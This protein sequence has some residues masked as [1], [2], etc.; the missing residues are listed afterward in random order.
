MSDSVTGAACQ[1]GSLEALQTLHEL[2]CPIHL[3]TAY[4]AAI[5]YGHLSILK[6]ID[7][8]IGR[9]CE[10]FGSKRVSSTDP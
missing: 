8:N 1:R 6:Y 9:P 4:Q 10:K 2:Q 5:R 7:Q 3:P